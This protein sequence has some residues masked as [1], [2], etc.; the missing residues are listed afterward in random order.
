M[1]EHRYKHGKQT[2]IMPLSAFQQLLE[3]AA[4]KGE[5]LQ[6]LAY[7]VFIWYFGVRTSEA[8]EVKLEDVK[9]LAGLVV[10]DFHTRKKHGLQ[11]E[12]N[13]ADQK[14]GG[15]KEFLVTWIKSRQGAKPTKKKIYF[16]QQTGKF[17]RTE[18]TAARPK[19]TR[20]EIKKR[21]YREEKAV[22][23]FPNISR[24]QSW[25]IIKRVLGEKYYPHYA[26]LWRLSKAA[27]TADNMGDMIGAVRRVSG[28]KSLSAMQAYF[29][30][31]EEVGKRAM[32]ELK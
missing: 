7:V 5:Q 30:D 23:L 10:V 16:Q 27:Q 2:A 13:E 25:L 14:W 32:R 12:P 18:P 24:A 1:Y 9:L 20:V 15:I 21:V 31:D 17:T 28:L 4:E 3:E 22:W 8:L 6:Y 26:R 29:G 19:G 11:V